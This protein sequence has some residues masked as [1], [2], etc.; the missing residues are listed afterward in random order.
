MKAARFEHRVGMIGDDM[1]CMASAFI[2]REC[3]CALRG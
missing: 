2:R 1:L 3:A